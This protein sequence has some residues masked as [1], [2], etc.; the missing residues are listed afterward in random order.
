MA[1]SYKA[2]R[3]WSLFL[4]VVWLPIYIVIAISVLALIGDLNKY[5]AIIV[6]AVL[7]VAWALPFKPLFQG[8]GKTEDG[9][10]EVE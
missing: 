10:K 3:R 5:L 7:G 9:N 2:R 6:Y 4:L 8:I 1:L